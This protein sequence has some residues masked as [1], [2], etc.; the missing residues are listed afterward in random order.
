[1]W[2]LLSLLFAITVHGTCDSVQLAKDFILGTGDKC[3]VWNNFLQSQTCNMTELLT[4]VVIAKSFCSTAVFTWT[5]KTC[6]EN[7]L[8]LTTCLAGSKIPTLS[9]DCTTCFTDYQS[10]SAQLCTSSGGDAYL[11]LSSCVSAKALCAGVTCDVDCTSLVPEVNDKT[12]T[13]DLCFGAATDG[14]PC[15]SSFTTSVTLYSICSATKG[16]QL[17][18]C[19]QSQFKCVTT[20]NTC[21]AT[22][23]SLTIPQ[24]KDIF[25]GWYQSYVSIWNNALTNLEQI[26]VTTISYTRD[27]TA[28]ISYSLDVTFNEAVNTID[29]VCQKLK[30]TFADSIGLPETQLTVTATSTTKR[31][32][33]STSEI[34]VVGNG[35]PSNSG[36]GLSVVMIPM[37]TFMTAIFYYLQ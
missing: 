25:D 4:T 24:V 21:T 30:E 9:M 28:S 19:V 18:V 8:V 29:E 31:G 32:L 14:C 7:T 5:P 22:D 3:V 15:Y 16:A 37:L 12:A 33:L 2:F 34:Q 20:Q 13:F 35:A 11:A 23:I 17:S 10:Y 36:S 26:T 27:E 1:M 6:L